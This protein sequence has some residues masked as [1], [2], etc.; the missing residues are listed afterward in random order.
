MPSDHHYII[1][2]DPG[3]NKI[4]MAV[5]DSDGNVIEKTVVMFPAVRE[6]LDEIVRKYKPDILAVGDGTGCDEFLEKSEN[7]DFGEIVR[8]PEKDTTLQAR[9]LAWKENPPGGLW[10]ILPRLFWPT[11]LDLDAW[12]AVVIGRR[13]LETIARNNERHG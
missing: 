3:R 4:G 6:P 8:I 13:A 12:A 9:E 7:Y 1:A 5:I 11:P 10:K 2:V